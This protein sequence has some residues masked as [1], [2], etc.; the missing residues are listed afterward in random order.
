MLTLVIPGTSV[1]WPQACACCLA[2]FTHTVAATKT[3]RLFLGVATVKRTLTVSV[4]YCEECSRH[5]MWA[6]SLRYSGIL[7][8]V[9][10][11]F[12]CTPF[13]GAAV[14]S[15][16]PEGPFQNA[17]ALL[18]GCGMPF[19]LAGALGVHEY[20][21]IPRG[22]DARHASKGLAVEVVDFDK[23]SITIRAHNDQYGKDIV[24]ANGAAIS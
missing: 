20:K 3:K 24:A 6:S 11:V 4:P 22:L 16:L 17:A 1:R 19:I 8:R 15:L 5:A 18:L 14:A 7:L 23:D 2:S 21:K 10:L 9:F 13:L 12:M